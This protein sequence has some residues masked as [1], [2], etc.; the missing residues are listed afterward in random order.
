MRGTELKGFNETITYTGRYTVGSTGAHTIA[1][2][3][4]GIV[5]VARTAAGKYTMTFAEVPFGPIVHAHAQHWPQAD[6]EPLVMAP[7]EGGY[8]SGDKTLLWEAW[9]I[10][11]T[12]AQTEIPSGDEVSYTVTFLKTT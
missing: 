9:V 8:D 10:D 11:E 12:A 2:G 5:G 7:S 6:A 4:T 1:A 3:G